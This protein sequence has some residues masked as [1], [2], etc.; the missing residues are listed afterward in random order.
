MSNKEIME[1]KPSL[2]SR[3]RNFF[4]KL[5]ISNK[6]DINRVNVITNDEN[7]NKSINKRN[8]IDEVKID[9]NE[10]NK[11]FKK[12]EFFDE[13]NGNEEAL[14]MLSIDRLKELK[15]YYDQII[16]QNDLKIKKLK[17]NL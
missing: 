16:E 3:I 12:K 2:I 5:F 4:K 1:Y 6:Q 11:I 17:A 8:F 10:I 15:K 9:A 13:I 14:S 7:I